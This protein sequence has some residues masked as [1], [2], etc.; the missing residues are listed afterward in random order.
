MKVA[1][2]CCVKGKELC[3]AQR[4]LPVARSQELLESPL[5]QLLCPSI[6]F[7]QRVAR[8]QMAMAEVR[9]TLQGIHGE[10]PP[11]DAGIDPQQTALEVLSQEKIQADDVGGPAFA[12]A[13]ASGKLREKRGV[14]D[15]EQRMVEVAVCMLQI[16]IL[17]SCH[18]WTK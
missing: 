14:V 3:T 2:Q 18:L 13:S 17:P 9:R 6:T 5:Q 16:A 10:A 7:M 15:V 4:C 8:A 12:Y 1:L 11:D